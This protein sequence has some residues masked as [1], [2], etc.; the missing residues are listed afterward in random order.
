MDSMDTYASI[1]KAYSNTSELSKLSRDLLHINSN[2][3]EAWTTVAMYTE[4]KGKPDAREK[5]VA[6]VDKASKL[7]SSDV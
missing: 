7:K 3:P 4:S 2:R 5:A 6:F 1:L